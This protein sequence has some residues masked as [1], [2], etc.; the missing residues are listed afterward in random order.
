V[1]TIE[2]AQIKRQ[3]LAAERRR[4]IALRELNNH[5]LQI[6][7]SA[8]VDLFLRDKISKQDLYLFLQQETAQLYRRTFDLA[9]QTVKEAE[10]ALRHERRDLEQL[11]ATSLPPELG[12]A[13]WD[14]LHTGPHGG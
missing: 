7:N 12:P 4:D 10:G 9:W 8:E 1:I 6:E 14:N 11:V 5:M 3:Q 13:G 2:I